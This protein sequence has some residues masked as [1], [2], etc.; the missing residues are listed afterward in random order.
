[1]PSESLEC[2]YLPVILLD[3]VYKED[4]K[5]YPLVFFEECKYVVKE[6]KIHNYFTDYE[7]ISSDSNEEDLLEKIH[8]EKKF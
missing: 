3:S 8:I 7:E 5:Y 6:K 2:V 4:N 1:M